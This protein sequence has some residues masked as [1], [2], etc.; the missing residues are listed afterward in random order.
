MWK[1]LQKQAC[2]FICVFFIKNFRNDCSNW[3]HS[4][5]E[6]N[7][8]EVFYVV[9]KLSTNY[10]DRLIEAMFECWKNRGNLFW[11]ILFYNCLEK[12]YGDNL[13]QFPGNFSLFLKKLKS[14]LT[15]RVPWLFFPLM[16]IFYQRLSS[17]VHKR[18]FT[19]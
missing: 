12:L 3:Y 17:Q 15:K 16:Y 4:C 8:F 6:K 14:L 7:F 9:R 13:V 2:Y 1:T 5:T 19:N 10:A 11:K 18:S